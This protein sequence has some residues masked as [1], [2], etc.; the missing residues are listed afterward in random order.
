[1]SVQIV[2]GITLAAVLATGITLA[3]KRKRSASSNVED[4]A[5]CSGLGRANNGNCET[6]YG[7]GKIRW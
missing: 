7:T 6:C 4:C 2:M 1:M 5:D 3:L